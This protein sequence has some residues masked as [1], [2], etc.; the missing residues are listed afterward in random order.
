MATSGKYYA[1]INKGIRGPLPPKELAKVNGFDHNTLVCQ[2]DSFGHWL[3][4][5]TLE[6]FSF[7]FDT[8]YYD[9]SAETRKDNDVIEEADQ[10]S[11]TESEDANAYKAVLERAIS[12]NGD[13]EKQIKEKDAQ[14]KEKEERL[15][16]VEKNI[17]EKDNVIKSLN[18]KNAEASLRITEAYERIRSLEEKNS[19]AQRSIDEKDRQLAEKIL[20]ISEST[21]KLDEIKEASERDRN[22]FADVIRKKDASIKDLEEKLA[23][24][25]KP[26]DPSWE[27][28]YKAAKQRVDEVTAECEKR[29]SAKDEQLKF[30][31]DTMERNESAVRL[32][33]EKKEK[34]I[35]IERER[36]Q[37]TLDQRDAEIS[38]LKTDLKIKDDE[39]KSFASRAA[40]AEEECKKALTRLE[41]KER[42]NKELSEKIISGN[43]D[44]EKKLSE[45]VS[46]LKQAKELLESQNKEIEGLKSYQS[47]LDSQLEEARKAAGETLALKVRV[48][49]ANKEIH[50]LSVE[51]SK[52]DEEIKTLKNANS[53]ENPEMTRL[54]AE[55]QARDTELS[56]LR[57]DLSEATRRIQEVTTNEEINARRHDEF[58]DMVNKKIA[59]LAEYIKKI[60]GKLDF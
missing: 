46:A 38:T 20:I 13:L 44:T 41:E 45:T 12:V 10:I 57:A 11:Q 60:E 53:G 1:Y 23:K 6:D 50:T 32:I 2:E 16:E 43:A 59:L 52:K 56:N 42:Q 3:D 47:N 58:Y 39:I 5:S 36:A 29:I 14:L 19:S 54:K 7:L 55:L 4:V 17:A 8:D 15:S 37:F 33:N 27:M 9:V 31:S 48:D 28:L 21:Q 25:P 35:R 18:E 51:N 40:K 22:E 24:A 49:Q 30:L 26:E 34:E